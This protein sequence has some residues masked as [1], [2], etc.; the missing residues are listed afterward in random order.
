VVD[1][2]GTRRVIASMMLYVVAAVTAGRM[3]TSVARWQ[4]VSRWMPMTV[5]RWPRAAITTSRNM[6]LRSRPLPW[7]A[8]IILF[9]ALCEM[10]QI[11]Q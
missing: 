5:R 2:S 9:H 7:R 3:K 11:E 4:A 1:G 6:L 8:C 10:C